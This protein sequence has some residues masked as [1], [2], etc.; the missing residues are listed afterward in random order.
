VPQPLAHALMRWQ[1]RRA[2]LEQERDRLQAERDR[3]GQG[4]E[5]R[6][7]EEHIV[8]IERQLSA[9]GPEPSAKMG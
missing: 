7:L 9:M 8:A 2:L 5:R 3:A 4:D 6:R 1:I